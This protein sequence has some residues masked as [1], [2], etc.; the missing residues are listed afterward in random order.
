MQKI[1]VLSDLI[2]TLKMSEIILVEEISKHDKDLR[3][4]LSF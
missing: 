2:F 3:N 1:E 4:Y